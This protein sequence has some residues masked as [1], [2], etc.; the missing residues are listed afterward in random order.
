MIASNAP[1]ETPVMDALRADSVRTASEGVY[2]TIGRQFATEW[3]FFVPRDPAFVP[4]PGGDPRYVP[5]G[6]GVW[7]FDVAG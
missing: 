3:G 1:T 2:I 7:R 6:E 5:L 4:A